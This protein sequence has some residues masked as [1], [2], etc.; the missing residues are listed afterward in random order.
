[1]DADRFAGRA[2]I[3]T[4]AGW[5]IGLATARRLLAE[6]ASL[7]LNDLD[8]DRLAG[9]VDGLGAGD[10]ALAVAGDV[11]DETVA[12]R[13][14][15]T[16]VDAWGGLDLLVNNVGGRGTPPGLEADAATFEREL[17]LCL[18]SAF[19]VTRAAVPALAE[20]GGAIA[21]VSSSAGRYTSDM[22]GVGYCA[23]KAGVLAFSRALASELGAAGI[24]CNCIAPGSTLTEQG[25]VD[26][27]ALPAAERERIAGGI[28]LGRLAE[29]E[30]MADVIAFLV[31]DDA[32]YV[33][34]ITVDVN[35]GYLMS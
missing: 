29:P 6:G 33:T 5:G 14:T 27:E 28:P 12:Q 18:T 1:M 9:A 30:D 10:R 11:L 19:L 17:D 23:G 4:G 8:G 13:L 16:V 24:R 32:R 34:G 20:R 26:W 2:G 7:V 35:G 15:T 22:A 25:R 21:F 3:V 31:S